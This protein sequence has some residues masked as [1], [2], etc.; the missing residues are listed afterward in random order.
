[1]FAL[2]I[3]ILGTRRGEWS[4]LG[5]GI[6]KELLHPLNRRLCRAMSFSALSWI[7][8]NFFLLPE[9]EPRVVQTVPYLI[10]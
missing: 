2:L 3:L 4:I 7:Y 10:Y 5:P 6:G 1:M 9:V 8:K